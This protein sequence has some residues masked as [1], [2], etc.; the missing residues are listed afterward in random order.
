MDFL[1]RRSQCS[2]QPRYF[3]GGGRPTVPSVYQCRVTKILTPVLLNHSYKQTN[4]CHITP[5]VLYT[6]IST[7]HLADNNP[8]MWARWHGQSSLTVLLTAVSPVRPLHHV[9]FLLCDRSHHNYPPTP[10]TPSHSY[11]NLNLEN[12]VITYLML[13]HSISSSGSSL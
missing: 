7:Y 5:A 13:S 11:H 8:H 1:M 9:V 3:P 10:A 12:T 4:S 2:H 6:N